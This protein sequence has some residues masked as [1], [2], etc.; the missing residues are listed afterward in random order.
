MLAL[1]STVLYRIVNL[2]FAFVLFLIL[3]SNLPHQSV[4]IF[5]WFNYSLYFLLFLLCVF[6]YIK[7]PVNKAI[8]FNVGLLCL[9]YSISFINLL[10]GNNYVFDNEY[11][12]YY[13]FQY[14]TMLLSFLMAFSV[15]FI[16]VRY[17]SKELSTLSSYLVTLAVVLPFFL[18]HFFPYLADRNYLLQVDT[19]VF[20]KS[21]FYFTFLPLFGIF[22]YGYL[23]YKNENS[24]GEYI[25][26]LMVCFFLLTMIDLTDM[27]GYIY[28]IKLFSLSQY[29]SLLILS[30]FILTFFRKLNYVYSD[31]GQFY[32]NALITGTYMGVPIKKKKNRGVSSLIAFVKSYFKYRRNSFIFLSLIFI[33]C[34]NHLNLPAYLK[35]NVAVLAFS[36]LLLF[37][38]IIVLYQKRIRNG[39]FV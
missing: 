20:Y 38:Y 2:W 9:L 34:L 8:F 3:I 17:M 30:F 35:L 15:I 22:F 5:S 26:A 7:E 33:L 11:L 37:F 14:R 10:I 19:A 32:E 23:L 16:C 1:K 18:W 36:S 12:A 39:E 6:I 31:F 28:E 21:M 4:P 24:L 25:N 13:V 27:F 29:V